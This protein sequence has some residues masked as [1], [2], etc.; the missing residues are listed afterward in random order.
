[1]YLYWRRQQQF[2]FN[3]PGH[4]CYAVP[5]ARRVHPVACQAAE[6]KAVLFDCDGALPLQPTAHP[7]SVSA[8]SNKVHE[9]CLR[10]CSK[11]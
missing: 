8:D 11:K 7:V 1:M 4:R 6:T 5:R 9:R 10:V 3:Q 2:W